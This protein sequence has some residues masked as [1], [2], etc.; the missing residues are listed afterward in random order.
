LFT[1]LEKLQKINYPTPA[2]NKNRGIGVYGCR[3]VGGFCGVGKNLGIFEIFK[4]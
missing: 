4:I 3:S 1:N 2:L